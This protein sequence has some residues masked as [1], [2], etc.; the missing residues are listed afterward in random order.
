MVTLNG[1][2]YSTYGAIRQETK[3]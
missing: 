1:F 2:V 3:V